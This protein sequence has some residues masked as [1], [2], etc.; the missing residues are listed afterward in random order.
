MHETQNTSSVHSKLRKK[1]DTRQS[2]ALKTEKNP[3][4]PLEKNAINTVHRRLY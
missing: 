2:V 4:R 3:Q 1:A